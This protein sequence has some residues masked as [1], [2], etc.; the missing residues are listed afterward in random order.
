MKSKQALWM[1]LSEAVLEVLMGLKTIWR[2]NERCGNG[3]SVEK[4]I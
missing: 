2:G 4:F 1:I 3:S